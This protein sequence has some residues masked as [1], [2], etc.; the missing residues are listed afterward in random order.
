MALYATAADL[1]SYAR[2]SGVTVP[3]DDADAE[4]VLDRAE[5]DVDLIAGPWPYLS[6]GRK[7]DPPTLPVTAFQALRRGTCAQALFRLAQGEELLIGTADGIAAIGGIA[8]SSSPLPRIGPRVW[9]ELAGHGLMVRSG[10]AAD[11]DAAA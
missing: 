1:R 8:F 10:I 6:T 3:A 7:F 9:E 2:D 5:I 11:F 4:R